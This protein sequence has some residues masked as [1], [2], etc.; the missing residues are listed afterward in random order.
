[1]KKSIITTFLLVFTNLLF[2]N[3]YE[4]KKFTNFQWEIT[5]RGFIY[6]NM[7]RL[8]RINWQT[9]KHTLYYIENTWD[10]QWRKQWYK[11]HSIK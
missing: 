3:E 1:M 4:R 5:S 8:L 11:E 2:A 9:N 10:P 6:E 7:K